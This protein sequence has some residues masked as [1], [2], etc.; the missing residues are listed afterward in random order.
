M[1]AYVQP[2]C[3]QTRGLLAE[4][5]IVLPQG[6]HTV[7]KA[8]PGILEDAENGLTELFRQL[9]QERRQQLV[10]LDEH[11]T[12]YTD[13]LTEQARQ[14]EALQQLQSIPGFGPIVA[15][16]YHTYVGNGQTFTCGRHV[17]ASLGLVPRQHSTGGKT[18]LLGISK[19]GDQ[20]LRGLLVHGARAVVRMAHKKEDRLSLWICQLVERRG[21]NKA[22]VALA[23]KLAR[24]AWAVSATGKPY[25]AHPA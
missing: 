14:S 25:V 4:Y 11:I 2:L 13:Q 10:E 16:A 22:T 12:F 8:L 7:R 18:V 15:S 3:N 19:R 9:L 5:G 17:S 20:E 6:V 21:V 1:N 24:T 23:N